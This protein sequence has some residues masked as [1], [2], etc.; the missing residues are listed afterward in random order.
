M[1][2]FVL[3]L[4]SLFLVPF[5]IVHCQSSNRQLNG[6][7][8]AWQDEFDG[9]GRPDPY[10]WS[11]EEGFVRNYEAQY[12]T[13]LNVVKRDGVLV[14]EATPANFA[15]PDY[16]P[17]S[18]NWRLSRERVQYTSGSIITRGH[19][20]F[21]YGRVEVRARIPVCAGAWPAIWLLGSSL[22]WP[23]N[24]EI[25]MLEYYQLD[26]RPTI[27]A[28]ACWAGKTEED[29]RWDDSYWPLDHFTANDPTW[30][31]RFHVWRMD[32][33]NEF[34]R[35]Y[36]DDELLN[37]IP[38]SKTINGKGGSPGINPFHRPFYL[39][40]N[41]ALDTRVTSYD[42]AIFPIR[43]EIDYVRIYHRKP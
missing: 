29:T 17:E 4:C 41:L 24:G 11:Y 43:Y 35:L 40:I 21:L 15:C 18:G 19:Y 42:P 30:A 37:E 16:D 32:W 5:S 22:P 1:T 14:I 13:P 6:Y 7:S 33:D 25:D 12:Y 39:L 31:S 38:L 27:L 36:L 2:R 20:S 28:N 8:L 23:G 34:I 10:K 9:F 3:A 26:G